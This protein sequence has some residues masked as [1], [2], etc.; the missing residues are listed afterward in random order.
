M[1]ANLVSEI[2][3]SRLSPGGRDLG[4]TGMKV[5]VLF[6]TNSNRAVAIG[7]I[8]SVPPSD[9][10]P[11]GLDETPTGLEVALD[12]GTEWR[13]IDPE[14]TSIIAMS[15]N[16]RWVLVDVPGGRRMWD[17]NTSSSTFF[18][19]G[20]RIATADVMW[21]DGS[22]RSYVT[23][24]DP[25][26]IVDLQSG[27]RTRLRVGPDANAVRNYDAGIELGVDESVGQVYVKRFR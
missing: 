24:S 5:S 8:G 26:W 22:G 21:I 15:S 19:A 18:P 20:S 14:A 12:Q 25:T 17:L 7:A 16:A 13:T 23:R 2:T 10:F 27:S 11:A 6:G 1:G 4:L 9:E 3:I